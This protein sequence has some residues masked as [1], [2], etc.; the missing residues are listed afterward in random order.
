[1][2]GPDKLVNE[3]DKQTYSLTNPENES[4]KPGERVQLVGKKAKDDSGEPT[5]EVQKMSKDLG[6]CTATSG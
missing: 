6:T 2:S 1:M 3:K 5:F 4:L